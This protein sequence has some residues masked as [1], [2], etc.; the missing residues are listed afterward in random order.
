MIDLW[1][2]VKKKIEEK[3]TL[4]KDSPHQNKG[5]SSTETKKRTPQ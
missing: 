1:D 4:W 5:V 2:L 3:D